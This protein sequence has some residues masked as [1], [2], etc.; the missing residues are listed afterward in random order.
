MDGHT[1]LLRD[2][3]QNLVSGLGTE[4]DKAT[5]GRFA[6][7]GSLSRTTV[8]TLYRQNWIAGKVIDAPADDMTR[9]WRAWTGTPASVAAIEEAEAA[10]NLRERVN[11]AI[12]MAERDGGSAILIGT[13]SD[14]AEPLVPNAVPRGGLRYLLNLSRW[15]VSTGMMQR[16]VTSP[17][18]GQPAEYRMFTQDGGSVAIHPSRLV[19]FTGVE[20]QDALLTGEPWGDSRYER[21]YDAIRDATAGLQGLASLMQEAKIDVVSIPGLT[22][23]LGQP[24]AAGE[25]FRA[26]VIARFGLATMLKG[27]NG[28]LLMD[29]AETWQQKTLTFA[30]YPEAMMVLFQAVAGANDLPLTK[31]IGRSPA[32]MNATG[33][34]DLEQYY[35]LI[36][37]RQE[38]R[39]RPLLAPLDQALIRSATGRTPRGIG[40]EWRALWSLSAKDQAEVNDKNASAVQRISGTG[41]FPPEVLGPVVAERL[42]EDDFL[43]ALR[44][45]MAS[46]TAAGGVWPPKPDTDGG[47]DDPGSSGG[48]GGGGAGPGAPARP[49]Q[50][51][52]P[53]GAGP[54]RGNAPPRLA[55]ALVP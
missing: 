54:R 49:T 35:G 34:S 29:A 41:L 44:E 33:E 19:I 53:S 38:T 6:M 40:H 39:L 30:G 16:D 26:A 31:L 48:A 3:L 20:R 8:E 55:G 4:R 10:L 36:R 22:A 47:G 25:K 7:R 17:W 15:D 11:R 2:S 27:I 9:E 42:D 13:G 23:G 32:G 24:G 43:P 52:A 45:A 50:P 18:F 14:P 12:K 5:Q 21:M 37:A 28:T 46:F 51:V 1:V